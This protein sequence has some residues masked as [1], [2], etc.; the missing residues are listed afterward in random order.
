[1]ILDFLNGT[2]GYIGDKKMS[3]FKER[4]VDLAMNHPKIGIGLVRVPRSFS[5]MQK[6]IEERRI[7]TPYLR[8]REYSDLAESIDIHI[9]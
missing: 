8:W 1:M 4:L 5:M 6:E 7:N 9:T 2:F 3:K